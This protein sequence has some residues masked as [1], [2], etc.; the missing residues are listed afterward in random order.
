MLPEYNKP[1]GLSDVISSKMKNLK[2]VNKKMSEGGDVEEAKEEGKFNEL[3]LIFAELL[4]AVQ[5]KDVKLGAQVL[6]DFITCCG[7]PEVESE[8]KEG[9]GALLISGEI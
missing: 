5:E 6:K 2:E 3:E 1:K 7:G 8:E 4:L 9:P